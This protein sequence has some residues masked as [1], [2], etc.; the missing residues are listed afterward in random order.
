MPTSFRCYDALATS[1]LHTYLMFFPPT[2]SY[3]FFLLFIM[4][5]IASYSSLRQYVC[6]LLVCIIRFGRGPPLLIKPVHLLSSNLSPP[7][8]LF[9]DTR[10]IYLTFYSIQFLGPH[11]YMIFSFIF[12]YFLVLL[13]TRVSALYTP[14]FHLF[15]DFLFCL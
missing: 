4:F 2:L 7:L 13:R 15:R 5:G 1:L 10:V 3:M 8:S 12:F 14:C 11:Y 6:G 9:Y